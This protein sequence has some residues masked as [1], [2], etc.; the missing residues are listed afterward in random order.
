MMLLVAIT[1]FF[2][3]LFGMP[4]II[5]VAKLKRLMDEPEDPRKIHRQSVPTVGGIMIFIA[6]FFHCLF[7]DGP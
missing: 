7:L 2:I 3:V 4:T 1:G 6:L 5:K